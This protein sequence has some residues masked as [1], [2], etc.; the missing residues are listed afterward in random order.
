M[1]IRFL[2]SKDICYQVDTRNI[3]TLVCLT[4]QEEVNYMK[5]IELGGCLISVPKSLD[6]ETTK[7]AYNKLNTKDEPK[8]LK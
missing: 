6:E 8:N 1:I 5:R 3:P 2:D 7:K 4:D